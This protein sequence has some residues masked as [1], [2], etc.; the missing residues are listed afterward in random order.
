M[1][2]ENNSFDFTISN[3]FIVLIIYTILTTF[4]SITYPAV[5]LFV[6][7]I[8]TILTT[9][10]SI[11][12]PAV[13][14]LYSIPSSNSTFSD[15][16]EIEFDNRIGLFMFLCLYSRIYSYGWSKYIRFIIILESFSSMEHYVLWTLFFYLWENFLGN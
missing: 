1:L 6:L 14:L 9:F 10:I 16:S 11:T 7:I 8:Y 4:I 3:S 15:F 12:Y 13:T 2:L 5:T